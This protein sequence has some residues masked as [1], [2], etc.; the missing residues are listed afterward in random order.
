[1]VGTPLA[2]PKHQ[3]TAQSNGQHPAAGTANG[4]HIIVEDRPDDGDEEAALLPGAAPS[5]QG[6]SPPTP[7]PHPTT[8]SLPC[9][10]PSARACS[11][12]AQTSIAAKHHRYMLQ[13]RW[14]NGSRRRSCTQLAAQSGTTWCSSTAR[15]RRCCLRTR[16]S[17]RPTSRA[18]CAA[19]FRTL[20]ATGQQRSEMYTLTCSAVSSCMM[21]TLETCYEKRIRRWLS[22]ESSSMLN[23]GAEPGCCLAMLRGRIGTLLYALN[24]LL[25]QS[26]S[27]QRQAAAEADAALPALRQLYAIRMLV[28]AEPSRRTSGSRTSRRTRC[29]AAGSQRR[30]SWSVPR[31]R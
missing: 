12:L 29:W 11:N 31:R 30:F 23:D 21:R 24:H 26:T 22:L 20:A 27:L 8:T 10:V 18:S 7:L 28:R 25:T 16:T 5:S 2:L 1:M 15:W 3:Q 14:E 4:R 17:W 19:Q 6:G 13:V 9:C